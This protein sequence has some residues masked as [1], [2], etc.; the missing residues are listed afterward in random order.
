MLRLPL[1]KLD[2]FCGRGVLVRAR[3]PRTSRAGA[4]PNDCVTVVHAD[5]SLAATCHMRRNDHE[6]CRN[7]PEALVLFNRHR[8]HLRAF[9]VT[10]RMV[11]SPSA[12]EAMTSGIRSFNS[13]KML[14]SVPRGLLLCR[15]ASRHPPSVAL[16]DEGSSPTSDRTDPAYHCLHSPRVSGCQ[17]LKCYRDTA[18]TKPPPGDRPRPR[19]ARAQYVQNRGHGGMR[20]GR[21][22]SAHSR[23][24]SDTGLVQL[25]EKGGVPVS[26]F[27]V[28]DRAAEEGLEHRPRSR[29]LGARDQRRG[30]CEVVPQQVVVDSRHVE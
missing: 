19:P 8:D 15:V 6:T 18:E 5:H 20:A 27:V 2:A 14:L 28:R 12:F 7:E 16:P 23:P 25:P 17:R 9:P 21:P 13:R 11:S 29:S 4:T 24:V 22:V 3:S 30:G 1:P 26:P 10:A